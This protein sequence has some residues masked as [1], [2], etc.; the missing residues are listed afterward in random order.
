MSNIKQ[1]CTKCNKDFLII[2]REQEFLK[3]KS[4]PFP[5]NCPTCR[6]TRRLQLRGDRQLFK[7][8][9]QKCGKEIVVS[10]NPQ[11]VQQSIYCKEDY[12]K[13]FMENDSII[14]DPLPDI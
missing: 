6:Q 9:C 11:K 14:K 4:L 2:D 10:F 13:F 8:N 3:Q 1:S 12:G 7:T 5:T